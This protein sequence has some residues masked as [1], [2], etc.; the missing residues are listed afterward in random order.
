MGGGRADRLGG[1]VVAVET[2]R[3]GST[4]SARRSGQPRAGRPSTRRPKA[5]GLP[6]AS[7]SPRRQASRTSRRSAMMAS[8][9]W[10]RFWRLMASALASSDRV[11]ELSRSAAPP[12]AAPSRHAQGSREQPCCSP[13]CADPS[14]S[15]WS[16]RSDR[17]RGCLRRRAANASGALL[18]NPLIH[19]A[20]S[21]SSRLGRN[22]SS[23][24]RRQR[25]AVPVSERF[26]AASCL[27]P[28]RKGGAQ[29]GNRPP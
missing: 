19:S 27:F 9:S 4:P 26:V 22:G 8:H 25:V 6:S 13:S 21:S 10:S 28:F 16:V 11:R 15:E 5:V 14:T 7:T 18:C 1:L 23:F 20:A 12:C 29:R 17:T 3:R 24:A 2:G